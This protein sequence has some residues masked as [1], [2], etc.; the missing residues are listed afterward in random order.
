MSFHLAALEA[1]L[2]A[3]TCFLMASHTHTLTHTHRRT[4]QLVYLSLAVAAKITP[5]YDVLGVGFACLLGWHCAYA[6][7][8]PHCLLASDNDTL[9]HSGTKAE[10]AVSLN[11]AQNF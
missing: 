8:S 7:C 5:N 3:A 6:P 11:G 1:S 2:A 4:V 9:W 10:L